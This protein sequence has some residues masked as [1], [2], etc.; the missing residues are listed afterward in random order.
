MIINTSDIQ[1]VKSVLSAIKLPSVQSHKGMNGKV[2]IVGGSS[3]F[4]SASFW[5]AEIA[6]H[7][8]DTV[9]YASTIE[10]NIIFRQTKKRF[11]NGIVISRRDID[12]YLKEDQVVLVGPGMMRSDKPLSSHVKLNI[13]DV[14]R[15]RTEPEFTRAVTEYIVFKYPEKNIVL[16]AGALQMMDS[17]WLIQANKDGIRTILT[18][19]QIEFQ[20]LFGVNLT[21]M[22]IDKKAS[23]VTEISKLHH[24]VILLK[25]VD[26]IISDGT[27][28]YII[29][30]GNQGL[31]KGGTGDILAGMTAG[32][33]AVNN[34]FVSA[35]AASLVLKK[36]ADSLFEK[37]GYWYNNDDIL[38]NI[39]IIYKK[40][41]YN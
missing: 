3:L 30:G 34:A 20:R 4:H 16:D 24:A 5:A 21:N 11:H 19:H 22:S 25:A 23:V 15:F 41:I 36:T 9:H 7:F 28:T 10:N 18:P 2:L 39:P 8:V 17:R 33:F 26:D 13:E 12:E 14:L 32:F 38:E 37:K 31:T 6:S 35:V 1:K 27:Q 29:K 40:L